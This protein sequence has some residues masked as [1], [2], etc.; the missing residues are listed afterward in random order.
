MHQRQVLFGILGFITIAAI[1]YITTQCPHINKKVEQISKLQQQVETQLV[2]IRANGFYLSNRETEKKKEHFLIRL[3]DPSKASAFLTQKGIRITAKEAEE[4]KGLMLAVDL[5]YYNDTISLDLYP[6]MLPTRLQSILIQKNDKQLLTRIEEMLKRRTLFAHIDVDPS[7]TAFQGYLKDIN[8]TMKGTKEAKLIL[9]GF[10]F[11]GNIKNEKIVE[12]T[13][14]LQTL[15]VYI[16]GMID[17]TISGL[18]HHY[19]LTGPTIYDYVQE[20]SIEKLKM[21][22]APEVALFAKQLFIH[23]T[24]IAKNGLATE[25]FKTKIKDVGLLFGKETLG[26]KNFSLDMN[27]SNLDID[28]FETLKSTDPHNKKVPDALAKKIFE[29]QIRIDIPMLS[30]EKLTL[31]GKEIDGFTLHSQIDI[32]SSFDISRFCTNTKH[33]LSKMDATIEL[34][35]SK[36]LLVLIKEEPE[37]MLLYM[38][39]RPKVVSDQSIYTIHLKNGL[40]KINGKE[41]KINR[42]EV[43]F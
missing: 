12:F 18:Q 38:M 36:D 30:V 31:H 14:R 6:A 25:K 11:S 42:K 5:S 39:H 40:I 29:K 41:L 3:E 22:E 19:A 2:Q 15:Y 8:E 13:Q 26:M 4:L 1:Y 24:S 23:S 9:H 37:V 16:E 32:D 20:Y 34:S 43:K 21:N 28:S 10:R 35:L 27:I 17:R 7:R 33:A